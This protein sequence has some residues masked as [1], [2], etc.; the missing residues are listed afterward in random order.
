M[1]IN[2]DQAIEF[3]I[4]CRNFV[5]LQLSELQFVADE[6]SNLV[7]AYI[8]MMLEHQEAI[9]ELVRLGL[10]GSAL[11]L[12]RSQL[13]TACRGLWV[14]LI[15]DDA[16][17]KAIHDGKKPF[18]KFKAMIQSLD[19][20]YAMNGF[21]LKYADHWK[22]LNGFAHSGTEQLYFRFSLENHSYVVAPSYPANF[23]IDLMMYARRSK[24]R[25]Q[26]AAEAGTAKY[27]AT[28]ELIQR[29]LALPHG[30]WQGYQ[31]PD[32]AGTKDIG[33]GDGNSGMMT[34]AKM[35]KLGSNSSIS[36]PDVYTVNGKTARGYVV[37]ELI[38]A[39]KALQGK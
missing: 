13:E 20:T 24:N 33:F 22:I 16:E 29:L 9:I 11:A 21:L 18:P 28:T 31:C 34:L 14:N 27:V 2:Q 35:L 26:S 39:A 8:A 7:F 4:K 25:P 3:N 17:I 12:I 15:A 6:R 10:T 36:P 19:K 30:W 5:T 32:S 23:P 37:A 38:A 1:S